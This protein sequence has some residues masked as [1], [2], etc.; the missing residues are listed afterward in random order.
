[1]VMM[2]PQNSGALG[3]E[4]GLTLNAIPKGAGGHHMTSSIMY[5]SASL[6]G[7]GTSSPAY[8]LD[9]S[10]TGRFTSTI[11][12]TRF[13]SNVTNNYGLVLN[14]TATNAYNGMSLQTAGAAKWFLGMRENLSSD[15]YI[16][17]NEGTGHD[18]LTLSTSDVASF[19]SSVGIG[20]TS[21][22][23]SLSVNGNASIG[24]NL[25][26]LMLPHGIDTNARGLIIAGSG[27]S[28]NYGALFLASNTTE[29]SGVL[30]GALLYSQVV[31]GKSGTNAASKAAISVFTEGSGGSV[32]GYG[33]YM[34]FYTRPD[35]GSSDVG[36]Y[37]RMRITSGGNVG[38]GTSSPS[39]KLQIDGAFGTSPGAYLSGTTYGIYG[40]NR[41]ASSASAGMNY[42]SVG[43]QKWFAG[44]YENSNNFGFYSVDYAGF[45]MVITT[46]G[47]VGIGITNPSAT[48]ISL[49][50]G[51][52][53]KLM[54][55]D[56]PATGVYSGIGQDLAAGNSTDIFAHGYANYGFITFGQLG[57]NKSTYTEWAR[58]TPG[59]LLKINS[60]GVSPNDSVYKFSTRLT[61]DRNIAFG[62]QG[63]DASIE[64]FNDAINA[65]VPLR[66]YASPLYV[67]GASVKMVNNG[68]NYNENIRTY[69]G[70]NDYSSYIM[71]AVS[72]DTGSGVGQ[73]SIV[74]WPS[75][76]SYQFTIRYNGTDYF[77]L[78]A[79]G[80]YS[81]YGSN[82]SDARKKTNIT[83]IEDNQLDTIMKLKPATF[84]KI[85]P[86]MYSE[87]DETYTNNNTHTGFIAQDVLAENIPNILTGSEEEGYGLDYDGILALAVKSIQELKAL[88][89]SLTDR[90][91]V[92][93]NK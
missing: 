3:S 48:K 11:N 25:T 61:T 90:I 46:G 72:G 73:W 13:I 14:R 6:V 50:Q 16:I 5:E 86:T 45:P 1:M 33:G 52:G 71:G 28:P 4:V 79:N 31:T 70:G 83:Y 59:G 24:A 84:S 29:A 88:I 22:T 69:A 38:I 85:N 64:A 77:Y 49:G 47:N 8:T 2:G 30:L 63:G 54:I 62:T 58:I 36:A 35:N 92:L 39:Y 9:V 26:P 18:V 20:F 80:N 60:S 42:Y 78:Y 53:A 19:Y 93:E 57:T 82:V 75:A 7:I 23:A 27:A 65:N 76:N 74:R 66:I 41:G 21:P 55:Y 32:G 67:V 34:A 40:A 81:F 91:E 51:I 17:H 68:T 89:Q 44:I 10:G 43:S 37:E 87:T 12:A 15:N 56:N